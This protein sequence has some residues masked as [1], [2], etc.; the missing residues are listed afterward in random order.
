MTYTHVGDKV[1]LEMTYGNYAELLL[2]LGYAT[3]AAN[4]QGNIAGFW[5]FVEFANK[6]NR[7]NPDFKQYE[8]P[9]SKG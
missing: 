4:H 6:L 1:T 5:S 2:I 9:S 3:G 8:M 7:T